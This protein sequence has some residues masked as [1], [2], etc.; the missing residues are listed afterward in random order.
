[1]TTGI[2]Q[3]RKQL[4]REQVRTELDGSRP[5]PSTR[6][7]SPPPVWSAVVGW[8]ALI[9]AG[10]VVVH[11][12]SGDGRSV[13]LRFGTLDAR[14]DPRVGWE[15]LPA[16]VVGL[17]AV[18][19]LPGVAVRAS[20]LRVLAVSTATAGLWAVALSLAD[21][22]GGLVD[23]LRQPQEYL[24]VL[25]QFTS[26]ARFLRGFVD[27]VGSY[28]V[29]VAGHPPGFVLFLW[30]LR[31]LGVGDVGMA[32]LVVSGSAA[33]V[34]AVLI[35]VREVAGDLVARAAAPFVAVAPAAVW[36]ATSADALD[37]GVAAWAV[38]L[39]VLAVRRRTRRSDALAFAGGVVFGVA[40]MCSYGLVL[41][42]LIP[43]GQAFAVRRIRPLV[44]AALGGATVMVAFAM[45]GFWWL[46]GLAATRG[47]YFDGIASRRPY[48]AF[49]LID[50][51]SFAVIVGP[52]VAV[53][54]TRLRDRSLW[55]LTATVLVVVALADL[56]GMSKGEVERIWLPFAVWL[57]PVGGAVALGRR[58]GAVDVRR[59]S[60][61]LGAQVACGLA[62]QLLV[63]TPW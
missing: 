28:P 48:V 47:R 14:W 12:V 41:L 60:R 22:V 51:S 61:W 32:L 56:S 23:P 36:V 33:A 17:A 34:P 42:A 40:A 46:D 15:V 1:M 11:I 38:A 24:A 3:I 18:W 30:W 43:I 29:H 59:A 53:G 63:R 45:A 58:S 37:A 20:W 25:P 5:E 2:S 7:L 21:G 35:V 4:R 8:V 9:V 52:A 57:L 62:L 27:H 49:L 19:F 26:P 6:S 31:A 39:T 55:L 13:G 50:L 10:G 44:V 16:I 54:F